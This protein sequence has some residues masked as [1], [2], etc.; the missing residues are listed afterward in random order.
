M[1]KIISFVRAKPIGDRTCKMNSA[2][3]VEFSILFERAS[4]SRK[5]ANIFC[6]LPWLSTSI[7]WH[8]FGCV[9][10]TG[11]DICAVPLAKV[12]YFDFRLLLRTSAM[13]HFLLY[14]HSGAILSPCCLQSIYRIKLLARAFGITSI[15]GTFSIVLLEDTSESCLPDV[16][17][18]FDS[19]CSWRRKR[20]TS[21]TRIQLPELLLSYP[22]IE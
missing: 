3:Q 20:H 18:T 4:I 13:V 6:D 12:L 9:Y 15:K 2:N 19:E 11:N 8:L 22:L 17:Y 10:F 16:F 21:R 1:L 14:C 5:K 7:L